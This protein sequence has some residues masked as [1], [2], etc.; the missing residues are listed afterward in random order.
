MSDP[1]KL[2]LFGST[3]LVGRAVM[4][5]LVGNSDFR[6]TAISRREIPLP[7]GARMEMRLAEPALW[8]DV[9]E[10]VRPEVLVCAL[11]TN[12][13]KSGRDEE[14]FRAVD[15]QLVLDLARAARAA[16][17]WHFI[18]VSSVGADMASKTL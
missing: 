4:D 5:E 7:S 2:A 16:G 8:G 14:A 9:I 15:E 12:W 1:V 13:R 6:L 10:T 17:V 3:G 11:G 18:L